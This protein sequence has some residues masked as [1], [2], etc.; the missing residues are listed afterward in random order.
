MKEIDWEGKLTVRDF[1]KEL[2]KMDSLDNIPESWDEVKS[3]TL[4]NVWKNKL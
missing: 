1:W 4:N 3:L 2:N